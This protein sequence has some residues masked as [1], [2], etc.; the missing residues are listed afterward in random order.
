VFWFDPNVEQC[1]LYTVPEDLGHMVV[2]ILQ[3]NGRQLTLRIREELFPARK[4]PSFHFSKKQTFAPNSFSHK[5]A[6]R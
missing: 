1:F 6:E 2:D 4:R 5:Q 3:G